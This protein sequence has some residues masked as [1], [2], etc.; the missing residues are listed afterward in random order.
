MK[1]FGKKKKEMPS[2]VRSR[3][4]E[5]PITDEEVSIGGKEGVEYAISPPPP[6]PKDVEVQPPPVP[7]EKPKPDVKK[8][9]DDERERFL[10]GLVEELRVYGGVYSAQDLANMPVPVKEA[11]FFTLLFGVFCELKKLNNRVE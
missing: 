11:E 9:L 4:S 8:P 10:L 6:F 5:T 2:M 1:M 7:E 3:V